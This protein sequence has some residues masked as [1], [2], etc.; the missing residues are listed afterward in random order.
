MF[1]VFAMMDG[2]KYFGV[3]AVYNIKVK[4]SKAF[5]SSRLSHLLSDHISTIFLD[6]VSITWMS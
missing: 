5:P 6:T 4:E 1:S 3:D 2:Y